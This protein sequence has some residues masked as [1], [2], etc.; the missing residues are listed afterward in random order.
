MQI[1]KQLCEMI[2]E[3]IEDAGKYANFALKYKDER[4]GL[5]DVFYQ[6]STEEMKHMAALH[7]EVVKI[8]DEFRRTKGEPPAEMMAVYDYLHERH[9]EDAAEVKAAQAL[10]R[11]GQ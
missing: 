5:A 11:E 2:G 1:I 7:G 10:Y 4:R 3:E 9:I 8:I 6:L